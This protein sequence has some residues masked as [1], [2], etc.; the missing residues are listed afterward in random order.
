M[1]EPDLASVQKQFAQTL[2]YK[3]HQL[4]VSP[5]VA[6]SDALLQIYRNNF[7]VTLSECL[8]QVYP[9]CRALVGETCFQGLAR[10]H[11]LHTPMRNPNV[12][13]YGEGFDD[14]IVCVP[15][16]LR[17]VPYL[18]DMATLEWNIHI[19]NQAINSP[20]LF[21]VEALS[22]IPESDLGRV[23]L[24]ISSAARVMQSEF[25]V[26]SIWFAVTKKE[27]DRLYSID[28]MQAQAFLIQPHQISIID[29]DE[30][31]LI[32]ACDKSPLGDIAPSLLSYLSKIMSRGI[33][34]DFTLLEFKK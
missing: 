13:R 23:Q 33:L 10:Y 7:V 27:E 34:T 19:V 5:G 2:Q 31:A 20:S 18:K 30:A 25:A 15:Q 1:T 4:P 22:N 28:P 3:P 11:V 8:A 16:V 24:N 14:T 26:A 32:M 9:V 12:E 17:S 29:A 6:G 21:P